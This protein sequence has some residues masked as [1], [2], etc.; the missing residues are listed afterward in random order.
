ME[1]FT[2]NGGESWD[3]LLVELMPSRL[4]LEDM[5]AADPHVR[6]TLRAKKLRGSLNAKEEAE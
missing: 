5:N 1:L 2:V 3:R 6:D 4:C